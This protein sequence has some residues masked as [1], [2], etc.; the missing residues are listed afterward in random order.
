MPTPA[1]G[2]D[3]WPALTLARLGEA[4][5]AEAAAA[6]AVVLTHVLALH[7][8]TDLSL[9]QSQNR[10]GPLLLATS[11]Y[12]DFSSVAAPVR[13]ERSGGEWFMKG[14]LPWVVNASRADF[15]VVP[16]LTPDGN[17]VIG[18]ISPAQPGVTVG[19]SLAL[20]GLRGATAQN[21]ELASVSVTEVAFSSGDKAAR[22]S[23]E[24]AYRVLGWGVVGL[25]SGIVT[26]S[27][28]QASEYASLRIQGGRRIIDH[29]PV[30]KLVESI[31]FAKSQLSLWLD[32][33]ESAGDSSVP[34]LGQAGRIAKSATDAALQVFGGIGYICP[35]VAERTWRDARQA[36]TLCSVVPTGILSKA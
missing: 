5:G 7:L 14:H 22:D 28:E 34:P 4:L 8:S 32:Q 17:R 35:G 18:S 24:R 19:K 3:D 12:W 27:C 9:N 31:V 30:S 6:F 21:V 1:D 20:L 29:S 25:L 26:K 36:A 16:A 15:I 11:P 33:L 10:S 23:L 13:A 2:L